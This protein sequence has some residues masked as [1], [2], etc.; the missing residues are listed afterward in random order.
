MLHSVSV[1]AH[2][3]RVLLVDDNEAVRRGLARYLQLHGFLVV[4]APTGKAAIDQLKSGSPFP[5]VLTDLRL[6]DIEGIE[7]IRRAK[8]VSSS[9]WVGLITGW[10]VD[11]NDPVYQGIE[12]VLLKPVDSASLLARLPREASDRARPSYSSRSQTPE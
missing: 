8:D 11:P 9:T 6:P 7:V 2:E 10:D 3:T 12:A 4:E 1:D 5:I